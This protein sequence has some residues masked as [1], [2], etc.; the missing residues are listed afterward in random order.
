MIQKYFQKIF[1]TKNDRELK[2]VQPFVSAVNNLEPTIKALSDA[3]LRGQT[4]K[5][6]D[7]LAQGATLDDLAVEAFATVREASVR[8][9]GMRHYDVQLIGGH[10]LHKG[11]FVEMRTGEGKTLV[12]TLPGYLNA[13]VDK[14]VHIVTVNDYL[15]K[16]DCE[17][18]GQVYG[19][20]GMTSGVIHTGASQQDRKY[21][22]NADICYGQ[23]NELGFDY[24]RDN[25]KFSLDNYV[26]RYLPSAHDPQAEKLLHY[27]IVDEVDSILIDEA[28]TPLIISGSAEEST[29]PYLK[30]NTV[31]PFLKKDLDFIVDEKGHHVSLTESGIDKVE[32]RLKIGNLY[33]PEHMTWVH[34]IHAALKAHHLYRADRNYMVEGNKVIIIDEHTGRKMPGRR[35]SDGLHQAVEAKEGVRIQEETHT[36]ATITF[37]NFFRMYEKLSGMT[38]TAETE[39]EEFAKVYNIDTVVI[40]TNKPVIR[41]D[42]EDLVFKTERGKFK[43][44]IEHIAECN[45]RGQPVLVGTIS[46][47][48]SQ[49]V[50]DLLTKRGIHHHVLNAKQHAREAD[51]VAQAGRVGSVTIATNM[52]GRG[53]DIVL[54]GNADLLARAEVFGSSDINAEFDEDNEDYK[55]ALA[56]FEAICGPEKQRVLAAGGLAIIGTERHE[57]RRIDNQLRGRAGRQ[58]DPGLAQFYLSLEDDLMRVFGGDRVRKIMEWLKIPED[59]P[60][61]SKQVSKAIEGSQR[62]VEGQNF[63][64][65][66][67]LLDY[68]DV[69]NMQ[70]KTVYALRRTV[71]AAD[72]TR[73]LMSKVIEDATYDVI[74]RY[75]PQDLLPK[76]WDI[77]GLEDELYRLTGIDIDLSEVNSEFSDIEDAVGAALAKEYDERRHRILEAIKLSGEAEEGL[78]DEELSEA[79]EEHWRYFERETYLRA[80][81]DNWKQHLRDMDA[82]KEGVFLNAYAQKDPKLI[83]KKEGYERFQELI[84]KI[85][86]VVMD[87]LFHVEVKSSKE[88]EKME[89]EA[90]QRRRKAREEMEMKHADSSAF[91][92]SPRAPAVAG[93]KMGDAPEGEVVTLRR[94]RPKIGRNDPCWCGSG[95]KYKKCHMH[96]DA[97]DSYSSADQPPAG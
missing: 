58:G 12:S 84:Q 15:A 8:A 67:N 27:A 35:W 88:L 25:M 85:N 96:T 70:R 41:T 54:G 61:V 40:P 94:S 42:A 64:S 30:A 34:Y 55:A 82:L 10:F 73:A 21:A 75:C 52:A 83:Y 4:D 18:M 62:R 95:K 9:L 68:D 63:D 24:L 65:R 26:H 77:D 45:E 39:A 44:A 53:T 2:K 36:L 79:A 5:F 48:K 72:E 28:R 22:Y 33:A 74:D 51:I 81:D 17:W 37:Q 32:Q 60:I 16:R 46:V 90:E 59:E 93:T 97:S 57:S 91:G 29:I 71:L 92:S 47:E 23:N 76:D 7:R 6:R 50:S 80:I 20:L 56:R 14:G 66:K 86:G 87:V 78:T 3:D 89:E 13:L 38:G 43:A 19:F 49:F 31:M 1:G 11:V 69:M